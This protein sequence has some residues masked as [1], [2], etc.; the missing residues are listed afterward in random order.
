MNAEP[1][2]KALEQMNAARLILSLTKSVQ[3]KNPEVIKN[4][5]AIEQHASLIEQ[6][7]RIRLDGLM[8][9]INKASLSIG[10]EPS[11]PMAGIE[12]E[13]TDLGVKP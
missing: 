7:G 12:D 10:P 2:E 5:M 4:L 1:V 13:Q 9:A 3:S 6:A 11:N 8:Q